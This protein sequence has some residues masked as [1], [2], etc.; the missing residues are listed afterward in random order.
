LG[1]KQEIRPPK[2]P[3]RPRKVR[4]SFLVEDRLDPVCFRPLAKL[5]ATP[6][7]LFE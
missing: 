5:A 3:K 7:R 1:Q 4:L 2:H 6:H